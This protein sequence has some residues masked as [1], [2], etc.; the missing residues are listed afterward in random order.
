MAEITGL[1]LY[2][3]VGAT[4][5]VFRDTL[6]EARACGVAQSRGRAMNNTDFTVGR[7]TVPIVRRNNFFFPR[8]SPQLDDGTFV[9][10]DDRVVFQCF[11]VLDLG[12]EIFSSFCNFITSRWDP[13]NAL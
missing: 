8:V 4:T 2:T 6:S 12:C 3:L 10:G 1:F 9:G 11:I 13:C 5:R 7:P